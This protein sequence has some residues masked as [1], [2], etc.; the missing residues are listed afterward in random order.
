MHESWELGFSQ[1]LRSVERFHN[2]QHHHT[3]LV[4]YYF[5]FYNITAERK[6]QDVLH[7]MK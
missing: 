6:V 1:V 3:E 5:L 2:T 7:Q 4:F